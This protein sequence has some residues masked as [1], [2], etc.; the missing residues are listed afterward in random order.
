MNKLKHGWGNKSFD[1]LHFFFVTVILLKKAIISCANGSVLLGKTYILS[2]MFRKFHLFSAFFLPL[3]N[4]FLQKYHKLC[5]R[6][7]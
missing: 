2:K 3:A 5:Y 1:C 4:N 7:T 6:Y